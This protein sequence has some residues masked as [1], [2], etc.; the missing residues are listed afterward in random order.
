MKQKKIKEKYPIK[1]KRFQ[2]KTN[3][4]LSMTTDIIQNEYDEIFSIELN[5]HFYLIK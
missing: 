3:K 4:K 1:N 5:G 2:I